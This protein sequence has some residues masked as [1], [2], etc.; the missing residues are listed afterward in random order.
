MTITKEQL[1]QDLDTL[2]EDINIYLNPFV[3]GDETVDVPLG[4]QT[5]PSLRKLVKAVQVEQADIKQ[6][7]VDEASQL[8]EIAAQAGAATATA[9]AATATTEANRAT[10]AANNA[11]P[12]AAAAVESL[13]ASHITASTVQ[14]DRA[15]TEANRAEVEA[16]RASAAVE[17]LGGVV[18]ASQAEVDAGI[19][20]DVFVSPLTLA[21][22]SPSFLDAE[23]FAALDDITSTDKVVSPEWVAQNGSVGAY[24]GEIR[25]FPFQVDQL[26]AYWAK[27]DGSYYNLDSDVGKGL[28]RLSDEY[29]AAWGIAIVGTQINVPRFFA[30]DWR[31]YFIRAVDGTLRA[32]GSVQEDAIRNIKTGD[33]GGLLSRSIYPNG[34]MGPL[35]YQVT[36][37][38]APGSGNNATTIYNFDFDASRV[39]PTAEDNRPLNV[40]MIPAIYY[41]SAPDTGAAIN[42]D[43]SINITNVQGKIDFLPFRSDE[44]PDGWYFTNG[45]SFE[46]SSPQG[47]VLNGFSDNYKNDWG[48]SVTGTTINTPNLFYSDGRGYFVRAVDGT[49]RQVGNIQEDALQNVTG[50]LFG[51]DG[52]SEGPFYATG[53][54]SSMAGATV[55]GGR[56]YYAFDLSRSA[57]TDT[58]TRPLNVGMT[59]AIYLGIAHD[60]SNV[61]IDQTTNVTNVD[62]SVNN[63]TNVTNEP[64]FSTQDIKLFSGSMTAPKTGLYCF[65]CLGGGG[66]GGGAGTSLSGGSAGGGGGAGGWHQEFYYLNE[67]R[68]IS[69]V[70]GAGGDGGAPS[71]ANAYGGYGGGY[72]TISIDGVVGFG[73]GGGGGGGAATLTYVGGGGGAGGWDYT[74]IGAG[75][76]GAG[77]GTAVIAAGAGTALTGG[78]GGGYGGSSAGQS[79]AVAGG[80][81]AGAGGNSG[82]VAAGSYTNGASSA[83]SRATG[84]TAL[85]GVGG[86]NPWPNLSTSMGAVTIS[87]GGD[88]GQGATTAS[89]TG[90]AGV[91]GYVIIMY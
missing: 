91:Q 29:R 58:E 42:G 38:N 36:T 47:L 57:R 4:G 52:G 43:I 2:H 46:L 90:G 30:D 8:A 31:G 86:K 23:D 48:I 76:N 64:S 15:T 66:G 20:D 55:G 11:A 56:Q 75:G 78:G 1:E 22:R 61:V 49:T 33:G 87:A 67:G 45:Q 70:V 77:Y 59:P 88:G 27:C 39:V 12:A 25:L 9:A 5:T 60:L 79:G 82:T 81:I 54:I 28:L 89:T 65:A 84:G 83:W 16:D 14:A 40:G 21:S 37:T 26:P 72:T 7:I 68:I 44:L 10:T 24:L 63:V 80:T 19:K 13:L 74:S 41:G 62:N 85:G 50:G 73:A 17:V 3:H 51:M 69:W 34:D 71:G 18:G 53:G 6:Q 35:G 32:V